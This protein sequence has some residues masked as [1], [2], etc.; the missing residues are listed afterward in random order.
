MRKQGQNITE[1]EVKMKTAYKNGKILNG[2]EDMVPVAGLAVL[3]EGET[4]TGVV[5]REKSR[6]NMPR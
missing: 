3:V 6:P 5:R 1:L 4:I 2:H